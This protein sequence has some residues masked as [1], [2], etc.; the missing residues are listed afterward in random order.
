MAKQETEI[1]LDLNV[2]QGSMLSEL[3]RTKK[4]IIGLK[5]EADD[6]KNAYKTGKITQEEYAK[7]LVRVEALLKTSQ[8]AYNNTQKAVTGVKTKM[9]DL[10]ASNNKL[11]Q[12]VKTSTENIRIG[13]TTVGEL[14]TKVTGLLNP[15][16]AAVGVVGALGAAYARSSIGAKDLEFAQNQLSF[17]TTILTD[18]FAG[19]FSSVEDGEGIVSRVVSSVIASVDLQTALLS[20]LASNAKE[21]LDNI[22]ERSGLVLAEISDR[23]AENSELLTEISNTETDINR[24]RE[25]ALKIQD[26]LSIN[27]TERLK[28]IDEERKQLEIIAATTQ[29]RGPIEGQINQLKAESARITAQEIKGRERVEKLLNG[30]INAENKRVEA[31]QKQNAERAKAEA[32]AQSEIEREKRIRDLDK[33]LEPTTSDP[34]GTKDF[35]DQTIQLDDKRVEVFRDNT[36]KQNAEYKKRAKD[37]KAYNE[38]QLALTEE[39]F[40]ALA[41]L[42]SQGSDARRIFALGAIGA[43]TAQAIASLTAASEANPANAFTFG[44]AGIAQYAAGIIRILANIV[45]AK[46]FLGGSFAGGADF[47]TSKPTMIMVGDNPGHRER[48][49]VEPLSGRGKSTY[50][51]RAGFAAFAG[52]GSMTFD[53]VSASASRNINETLA[54]AN[55]VKR[56]PTPEVSVKEITKKQNRVKVKENISRA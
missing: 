52:G 25:L 27:A 5:E 39:N 19:L 41:G 2:D 55:A 40:S 33:T 26:N 7:E 47:V 51:P 13:G 8:S 21:E 6:L 1:V 31:L 50:N 37:L 35:K 54:T 16:T 12:S 3:E 24:K 38:E 10:I 30:A 48:V 9:D 23:V 18:K 4:A 14:T 17:A 44:G 20:K 22:K 45:A 46:Q 29:D 53:P 28:L 36:K 56:M 43:D 34:F 11:A 42:F 32:F 15:V 49:T